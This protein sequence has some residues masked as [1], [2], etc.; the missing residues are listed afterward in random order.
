MFEQ[1]ASSVPM[2]LLAMLIFWLML[3]FAIFGLFVRPN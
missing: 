3:L 2:P 1:S